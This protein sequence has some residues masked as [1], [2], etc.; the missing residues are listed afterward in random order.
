MIARAL[1]LF[2]DAAV[3][4]LSLWALLRV[5]VAGATAAFP[6]AIQ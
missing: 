3:I 4:G 1:R 6:G 5:L 2:V